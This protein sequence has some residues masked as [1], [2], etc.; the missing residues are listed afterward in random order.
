[1]R[2]ILLTALLMQDLSE[3]ELI[4][5][6]STIF[7]NLSYRSQGPQNQPMLLGHSDEEAHLTDLKLRRWYGIP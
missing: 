5:I 3:P 7:R 2:I 1:M 6:M 4:Y